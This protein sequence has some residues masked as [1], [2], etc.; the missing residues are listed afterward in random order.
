MARVGLALESLGCLCFFS[1]VKDRCGRFP[2]IF[3]GLEGVCKSGTS[4]GSLALAFDGI[5]V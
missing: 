1:V 3:R 5:V 4:L 2:S